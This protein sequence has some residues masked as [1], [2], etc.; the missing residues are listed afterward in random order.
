MLLWIF[1]VVNRGVT[2]FPLIMVGVALNFLVIAA[3]DGMPVWRQAL[4]ASGQVDTVGDLVNEAD[5][6]V[7]HHLAGPDDVVLFLGDVIAIPPPVAQAISIG[8]IF[9]YGGVAVVVVAGMRRRR[10]EADVE[11][12]RARGSLRM[13][14]SEITAGAEAATPVHDRRPAIIA[15]ELLV[16][17]PVIAWLLGELS[18]NSQAVRGMG[19]GRP[20]CGPSRS[21]SPSCCPWPRTCRWGSASRSP[22][23]CRR[24]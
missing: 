23:S 8:D 20:S 16:T 21:R 14:A 5:S 22:S 15:F 9:T 11:A 10:D 7:K 24:P 3:N 13:S 12:A 1:A 2:G 6:Y 4:V 18:M 19:A 17:V